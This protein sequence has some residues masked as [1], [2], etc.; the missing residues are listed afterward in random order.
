MDLYDCGRHLIILP[1]YEACGQEK[2][3]YVVNCNISAFSY[4]S[5]YIQCLTCA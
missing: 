1:Q 4:T 5:G 2:L 3:M